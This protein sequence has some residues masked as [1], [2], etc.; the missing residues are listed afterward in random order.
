MY[1]PFTKFLNN[2]K[3]E[4]MDYV[5]SVYSS[6]TNELLYKKHSKKTPKKIFEDWFFSDE[7]DESIKELFDCS[8]FYYSISEDFSDRKAGKVLFKRLKKGKYEM[9]VKEANLSFE[10]VCS[11]CGETYSVGCLEVTTA[12]VEG[13]LTYVAYGIEDEDCEETILVPFNPFEFCFLGYNPW[14][15]SEL[16]LLNSKD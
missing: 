7:C 1:C 13:K 2:L 9:D 8:I 16:I 14:I 6:K 4:T 10:H 3:F 12:N 15:P 5:L 11:C